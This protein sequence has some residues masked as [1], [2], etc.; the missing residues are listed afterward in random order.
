MAPMPTNSPTMSPT[1]APTKMPTSLPTPAPTPGPS[2]LKCGA[3]KYQP[4]LGALVPGLP[5]DVIPDLVC[6]NCSA[7]QYRM[8]T[9]DQSTCHFRPTPLPTQNPTPLPTRSP[10]ISPTPHPTLPPTPEPVCNRTATRNCVCS[11]VQLTSDE[12]GHA[13]TGLFS[14][15]VERKGSVPRYVAERRPGGTSNSSFLFQLNGGWA[16]GHH[17]SAPPY[18]CLSPGSAKDPSAIPAQWQETM[19]GGGFNHTQIHIKCLT[20]APTPVPTPVPTRRPTPAPTPWPTPIA[21]KDAAY[22]A[23]KAIA[24]AAA[25]QRSEA[26]RAAAKARDKM[27]AAQNRRS[28]CLLLGA[29]FIVGCIAAF[30]GMFRGARP[31]EDAQQQQ[32]EMKAAVEM[33]DAPRHGELIS[34]LQSA[35]NTEKEGGCAITTASPPRKRHNSDAGVYN[36]DDDGAILPTTSGAMLRRAQSAG[37]SD[38]D[39]GGALLLVYENDDDDTV[40]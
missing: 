14:L 7:G 17:L 37:C 1:K 21:A 12:P 16:I 32:D 15:I 30:G 39:E 18:M 36:D 23:R 3:D 35:Y 26:E 22:W 8:P 24:A 40:L 4:A 19:A 34:I 5:P 20:L 9:D 27:V 33:F 10:T 25:L 6:V 13:C 2:P 28:Q 31:T 11:L 38:D 29:L